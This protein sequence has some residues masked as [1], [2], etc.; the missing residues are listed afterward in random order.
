MDKRRKISL[1]NGLEARDL[2]SSEEGMDKKFCSA[3]EWL[4]QQ[5]PLSHLHASQGHS[6]LRDPGLL[7]QLQTARPRHQSDSANSPRDSSS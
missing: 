4:V 7:T 6:A 3:K 2:G 5:P 1:A